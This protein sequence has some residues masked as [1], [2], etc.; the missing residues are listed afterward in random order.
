MPALPPVR[1]WHELRK[2]CLY[3]RREPRVQSV[4][5]IMRSGELSVGAVHHDCEPSVLSVSD[6][7]SHGQVQDLERDMFRKHDL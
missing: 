2:H 5:H 7:V 3:P 6:S 4:Q 1:E